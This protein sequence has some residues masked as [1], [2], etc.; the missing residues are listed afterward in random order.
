MLFAG[1]SAA[2]LALLQG[3]SCHL[4][5][6]HTSPSPQPCALTT[7]TTCGLRNSLDLCVQS[8][9]ITLHSWDTIPAFR[10]S[11]RLPKSSQWLNLRESHSPDGPPPICVSS[12]PSSLMF[13]TGLEARALNAACPASEGPAWG[14]R[15]GRAGGFFCP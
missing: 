8:A 10:P 7:P 11:P 2:H 3:G 9:E 6:W 15:I 1:L 4:P 13:G 5:P 14:T 12:L